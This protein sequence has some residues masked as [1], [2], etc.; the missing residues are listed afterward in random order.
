MK[1][2]IKKIVA[3]I[4]MV[5]ALAL[6]VQIGSDAFCQAKGVTVSSEA[7]KKSNKST[8]NKAK[9]KTTKIST[10]TTTNR[11]VKTRTKKATVTS[12]VSTLTIKCVGD[13]VTEGM[14]MPDAHQAVLD[15]STYPSIL[16]TMLKNNGKE[17]KVENAGHGGEDTATILARVGGIPLYV[18][19]DLKFN[20]SGKVE[21]IDKKLTAVFSDTIQLPISFKYTG[22]DVNPIL[23]NGNKYKAS[24]EENN[25]VWKTALYRGEGDSTSVIPAGTPA[26]LGG[27]TGNAVTIIFA[28][29]NDSADINIDKYVEMLKAGA[30]ACGGNY[31]ILGPHQK[32]YDKANF[33]SGKTS[34]ERRIN[35]R[36]RMTAE[37]G[38]RFVDLNNDWCARALTVATQNGFFANSSADQ[39]AAIQKKLNNRDIPAEF[40]YNNKAYN[41]HLNKAG[42]TVIAQIVYEK[43]VELGYVR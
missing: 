13:S 16:Y 5:I 7:T 26:Q 41:V 6:L 2:V 36:N 3:G 40:T 31:I 27:S 14:A 22:T 17:V 42:Y 35:Y 10:K 37:F 32:I 43:L 23:I 33:V 24:L 1:R 4:V 30:N 19:E 20:G 8:I 11:S 34:E 28:G 9:K 15:G 21:S 18:N 29:I 25:K 12:N 38:N 39:L